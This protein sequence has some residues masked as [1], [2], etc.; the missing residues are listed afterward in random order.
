MHV[1]HY[2]RGMCSLPFDLRYFDD[3]TLISGRFSD[4]GRIEVSRR[5][6]Q[7]LKPDSVVTEVKETINEEVEATKGGKI[8]IL[9]VKS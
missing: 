5:R 8:V 7:A 6:H 4:H 2:K 3:T 1:V 9:N